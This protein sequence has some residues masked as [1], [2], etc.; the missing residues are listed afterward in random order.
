[1]TSSPIY[2]NEVEDR[3]QIVLGRLEELSIKNLD[4]E[5]VDDSPSYGSASLPTPEAPRADFTLPMTAMP[6]PYDAPGGKGRYEKDGEDYILPPGA[7]LMKD[8][9]SFSEGSACGS[10]ED[11]PTAGTNEL[12]DIIHSVTPSSISQLPPPDSLRALI[13]KWQENVRDDCD[14]DRSAPVP[15]K[16]HRSPSPDEERYMRR[17]RPR[18]RAISLPG[19]FKAFTHFLG[20]STTRSEPEAPD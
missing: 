20:Y 12:G 6:S 9:D 17:I 5:D 1:M 18:I 7:P 19:R 16:R 15:T 11:L 13:L 10:F 4:C 3:S 14:V 8:M 2:C